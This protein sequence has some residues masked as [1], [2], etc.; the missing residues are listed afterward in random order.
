[1]WISEAAPS[2]FLAW[3]FAAAAPAPSTPTVIVVPPALAKGNATI[4]PSGIVWAPALSRYLVVSDDTG[5][6]EDRHAPFVLALST[7]GR[8]DEE[9]VPLV[10]VDELNDAEAICAGPAGTFFLT[11]S[12]SP[13]HRGRT[14]PAR[15]MLLHLA[16]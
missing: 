11:T 5:Q 13:N 3:F 4:E 14:R 12:H 2:A 8:F 7:D 16:L 15:R 6:R 10:G 9:P 1:M